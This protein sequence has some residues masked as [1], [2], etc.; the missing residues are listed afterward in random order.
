MSARRM[1]LAVVGVGL[2]AA[3]LLAESSSS[4]STAVNGKSLTYT[5][6]GDSSAS[7]SASADNGTFTLKATVDGVKHEVEAN[8]Q[9]LRWNKQKVKLN[10]FTKIVV[11]INR[12]N[13]DIKVDGKKKLP[14]PK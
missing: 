1:V 11:V 5:L 13:V 8:S 9:E 12:K 4:G 6:T 14:A 2:L 3:P 7:G 10:G